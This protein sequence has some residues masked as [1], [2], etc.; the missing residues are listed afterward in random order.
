MANFPS[1]LIA[2]RTGIIGTTVAN[3]T[4][5]T[6]DN[7]T[8][9]LLIREI[10]II[11]T[12]ITTLTTPPTISVGISPSTSDL[13]ALVVAVPTVI[14]VPQ[15]LTLL[16]AATTPPTVAANTVIQLRVGTAAVAT[17]YTFK[18]LLFGDY[19]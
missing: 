8:E 19:T 10:W 2:V 9:R 5:L 1:G 13:V 4:I 11:P 18:A 14:N 17:T 7:G 6:T 15:R 3:T 16:A 12:T